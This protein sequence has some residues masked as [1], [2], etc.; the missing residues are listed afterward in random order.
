MSDVWRLCADWKGWVR[1]ISSF[2]CVVHHDW[3][4][5]RYFFTFCETSTCAWIGHLMWPQFNAWVIVPT[6]LLGFNWNRPQSDLLLGFVWF[7][8]C[9]LRCVK[10][11]K[12]RWNCQVW[13]SLS[14]CLQQWLS[15]SFVLYSDLLSL[16]LTGY[17]RQQNRIGGHG[18]YWWWLLWKWGQCRCSLGKQRQWRTKIKQ[19]QPMQ[20]CFFSGTQFEE[21][22]EN[23]QWRKVK[24]MQPMRLCFC[25]GRRFEDSFENAQWRK[26]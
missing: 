18:S 8:I 14:Y 26:V 1:S 4:W 5:N 6:V 11:I 13:S 2:V 15:L 3:L 24:Q 23:T 12:R 19:M 7:S 21:A 10:Q 9:L 20:L 25:P 17:K 22:F 16:K